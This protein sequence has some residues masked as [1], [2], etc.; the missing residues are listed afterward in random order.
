MS[1][2]LRANPYVGLRPFF[3][4]DS[5]YFYG[6]EKQTAE[7]LGIL[8]E[9]RFLSVVGSSGSG[10]SSLVRAGLLPGLL[11]GFLVKDRDRWSTIQIKPG[12]API[13]NLAAGLVKTMA[14]PSGTAAALE[15]DIREQHT[16]AVVRFLSDLLDQRT[17]VFI[18]VDQFEEIFAFRGDADADAAA[19]L[20]VERRKDRARRHS[21][22]ADF[23]DLLLR[24]A[25]QRD[26]PIYVALTMR[27]DFLGECDLFYGLPEA[28][29]RGRYLVPR[30][31][32]EQL[33]DAIEC[34][35]LLLGAEMAPRLLDHV[36]NELGD[37]AD[38]LP[39]L[40]H[41]LLRT[42]DA[43]Q[44]A[45]RGGPIDLAHYLTA[46]GIDG[47]LNQDAEGAMRGLDREAVARIF[48]RLTDTDSSQRRVRSP[49]RISELVE[50]T[51]QDRD[52]VGAIV[53]RFQ[54]DGRNFVYRAADGKPDDPRIDI[55][56]ESLI[57]Q[58][59]SLTKWVD[60]ESQSRD[61]YRDLV[62]RAHRREAGQAALLYDPELKLKF[63]WR[64][65][66]RPSAG[67]AQR[68]SSDAGDFKA[69]IAFLDDSI[70]ERSRALGD[71]V[72]ARRWRSA[73][74]PALAVLVIL[75]A[76]GGYSLQMQG[77]LPWLSALI[78]DEAR[79][80]FETITI[81]RLTWTTADSR[82]TLDQR[83]AEDYCLTRVRRDGVAMRL[84]TTA[85]LLQLYV[86]GEPSFGRRA[87]P[88][89]YLTSDLLW[90]TEG[91]AGPASATGFAVDFKHGRI[92]EVPDTLA[93]A[94]TAVCVSEWQNAA[95]E[96]DEESRERARTGRQLMLGFGSAGFFVTLYFV[97]SLGARRIQ[98]WLTR[99]T[100]VARFVSAGGR[101]PSRAGEPPAVD[102]VTAHRAD[103]ASTPRRFLAWTLD[104]TIYVTI[105]A[106]LFATWAV[107]GDRITFSQPDGTVVTGQLLQQSWETRPSDGRWASR[108]R[109]R[110]ETDAGQTVEFIAGPPVIAAFFGLASTESVQ[111]SILVGTLPTTVRMWPL[112]DRVVS[113]RTSDGEVWN[114]MAR[115]T[116]DSGDFLTLAYTT[117]QWQEAREAF[118]RDLRW[119]LGGNQAEIEREMAAWA[120]HYARP[121]PGATA[122]ARFGLKGYEV[123][124]V[125][126]STGDGAMLTLLA[127][128]LIVAWL[129]N[130]L[131]L[132]SRRQAT[133]GMRVV[134]IF[135][136]DLTG[137]RLHFGRASGWFVCRILSYLTFGIGFFMQP[138]SAKR[139][140]LHDR[141]AGT[142]VLRRPPSATAGWRRRLIWSV[143][144][145]LTAVVVLLVSLLV[146]MGENNIVG[147]GPLQ[148]A[149][150]ARAAWADIG[151]DIMVE[152]IQ[153][154]RVMGIGEPVDQSGHYPPLVLAPGTTVAPVLRSALHVVP[155]LRCPADGCQVGMR[156]G[157]APDALDGVFSAGCES[158][159][160]VSGP[161]TYERFDRDLSF[162]AP[163]TPGEYTL[164]MDF[165][166]HEECVAVPRVTSPAA[167]R[168]LSFTVK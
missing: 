38:R 100:L 41:A 84:P 134:G 16:D 50:A 83:S 116:G 30:L 142:V 51:G 105:V 55:S 80:P 32:R 78:A 101:D 76:A 153:N 117:D 137:S 59:G 128:G 130:T 12:D 154:E 66:E 112:A 143:G 131:Q 106:A 109:W 57:R 157:V 53:T 122:E 27:T 35:A 63:D 34:P 87:R 150:T 54:E 25:E 125:D 107:R 77:S 46:G 17:N 82:A 119:R 6:R 20:D 138:F 5:L 19:T 149:T 96:V 97:L 167:I 52:I 31:T 56:H 113:L 45:G 94:V 146:M 15:E 43:W 79:S 64:T 123:L 11:G 2:D 21:E 91:M 145:G 160:S 99:D 44:A 3:A 111:T 74:A 126:R 147:E 140:A 129:Y 39:M 18:L 102:A 124:A 127:L 121:A 4:E 40:Q 163:Q 89:L 65:K 60:D 48:K 110:V 86:P 95:L 49:A 133:A 10:K 103:Y 132:T 92:I 166:R 1:D 144:G 120:T 104:L 93:D 155:P 75:L 158:T 141:L 7:L 162:T 33:R 165:V 164:W 168:L 22:A 98:R 36:L 85:E 118:V 152:V 71:M 136:T 29:N 90:S 23:V 151:I 26:L 73:W 135:R 42:W 47:A 108:E 70:L 139:Q 24:L 13:A 58:W 159:R 62:A 114:G 68:Y 115:L 81:G 61:I 156:Y 8:R 88:E 69:A 28:L 67:W 72:L 148:S 9:H 161:E 14:P 37:R